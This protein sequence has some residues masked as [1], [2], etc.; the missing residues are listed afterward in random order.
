MSGAELNDT[1]IVSE[2]VEIDAPASFVWDV[3]V[4]FDR[5]SDWNPFTV[6]VDAKLEM[7]HP[8]VLHLPDPGTP[9]KTF[10]THEQISVIEPPHHLQYNT[11]DSIPGVHA[12]R[13]QWVEDLGDGRSA[14]TETPG[15]AVGQELLELYD[16]IAPEPH[17]DPQEFLEAM[18]AEQRLVLRLTPV[19][20]AGFNVE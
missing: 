3:I 5:Y 20:A 12:I 1:T 11:G 16:A 9:G 4:D 17:P 8:V 15:D 10:E 19:S 2:R 14:V 7:G 18:V 13:D 6:R